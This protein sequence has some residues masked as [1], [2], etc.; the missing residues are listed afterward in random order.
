M[1]ISTSTTIERPAA[2]VWDLLGRRFGE[3]STWAS[4]ISASRAVGEP[5]IAGAPC[6]ERECRVSV[7]G[8]DRLVEELVAYDDTAMTLTYRLAE[9]MQQVAVSAHNTWS[10]VPLGESRSQLRIEAE[11]DLA[12][13]GRVLG[14]VLRPYLSALG[15]RNADDFKTY[16]ETGRPSER[17]RRQDT[18]LNRLTVLVA[19]NAVFTT[20][21]GA[22]LVVG[23]RW[24]ANQFGGADAPIVAGLGTALMAY[25]VVLAWITGRGPGRRT[26]QT[27]ALLDASWVLGSAAVLAV[28]GKDFSG[29]GLTAVAGTAAVVTTLGWSQWR[30]SSRSSHG[31][32]GD[33]H[34]HDAFSAAGQ[35]ARPETVARGPGA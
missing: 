5:T 31:Q 9:G 26:G 27:L 21:S 17:K 25:A 13:A 34:G 32:A 22:A 18:G 15:R 3:A 30:A 14:F 33:F 2:D 23:S 8:A 19:G 35:P 4:S 28:V 7:P 11:V 16:V 6:D 29:A 20:V 24:W 1:R 10:V 12:P